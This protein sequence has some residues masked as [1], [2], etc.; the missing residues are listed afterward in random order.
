MNF[1][2]EMMTDHDVAM[3][4]SDW[5]SKKPL[6]PS[7]PEPLFVWPANFG[8]RYLFRAWRYERKMEKTGW[9]SFRREYQDWYFT[10]NMEYRAL[11]GKRDDVHHPQLRKLFDYLNKVKVGLR[12][13][14]ISQAEWN[15]KKKQGSIA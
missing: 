12:E 7:L 10:L 4:I 11:A 13:N 14:T 3:T 1:N 6:E 5:E 8:F 15:R 9:K 2:V